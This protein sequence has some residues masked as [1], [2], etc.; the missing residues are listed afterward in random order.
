M[1]P[2]QLV[3]ALSVV[4][5]AACSGGSVPEEGTAPGPVRITF[6][7]SETASGE[8]N[9]VKLVERFNALQD[10]VKVE[11]IYQ[12]NDAELTLKLIA[13][14]RSGNVPAVAYMSEPYTQ[15]LIDSRQVVPVQQY[16]DRDRFD[17]SDFAPASLA[18]YTVGGTLY[19]MPHGL[20]VPL[21][22]YNKIPF[23]EVGLDP[24]RPPR[25]LD[26]AR[27]I[28]EKLQ[29]RDASGNITRYGFAQDI[30]PWYLEVMLAGAGQL[31][32]NND[33]GRQGIATATAFDNF[34]GR[35]FFRWWHDMAKDGLLLNVGQN[36][37]D[38]L[39]AIGAH[40]AVMTFGGSGALRSI[41]DVLERG[42]E[43]IEAGVAPIPGIPGAVPE[44]SPGVYTRAL[45]IM[46]P[47]PEAERD[48]GWTFIKWLVAPEQQAEWFAGSGYLPVRNSAYGY[49]AARDIVARYPL[50]Q[51]PV[52]LFA[53]T[54]TT[55]AALGP[56]LGPFQEVR[57]AVTD[58][59]ESMLSGNTS[60]DDAMDAAVRGGDEA[61]RDYNR[62]LGR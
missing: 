6:W 5:L 21:L 27:A 9:L 45:W 16:V 55:S 2:A 28:A 18:Y 29:Q 46:K 48:A 41:V 25:D 23:R 19:A 12:G 10:A 20:I 34:A 58:A 54:A 14:L 47:R 31:Y 56:L 1:R 8:Q 26:E 13:G 35:A 40:R 15:A 37:V 43:G 50:F 30:H 7:H 42:M 62:R 4:L 11:P 59:I 60:P 3:F 53:R 38:N 36:T 51:V 61:I 32:V 24:D 22:F 57:A 52:D 44:G 17:L 49:P 39:L 33:N